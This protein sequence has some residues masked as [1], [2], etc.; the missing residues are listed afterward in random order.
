MGPVPDKTYFDAERMS[1]KERAEFNVWY[2]N[3]QARFGDKYC[4]M[5]GCETYCRNDVLVLGECCRITRP[6]FMLM[7][8]GID[9]FDQP[10]NSSAVMLGF[11]VHYLQLDTIGVISNV[12]YGNKHN[13]STKAMEW[14][15]VIEAKHGN[16]RK[17]WSIHQTYMVSFFLS[18]LQTCRSSGGEKYIGNIPLDG[19]DSVN[20]V[21][22]QFH[23]WYVL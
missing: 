2:E 18:V 21:A 19:W 7:F 3:A 12:G 4:L 11:Q 8:P 16:S 22:F 14:L 9:L 10:T 15:A 13:Q 17:L 20:K 1:T 6:N 5:G 23:G